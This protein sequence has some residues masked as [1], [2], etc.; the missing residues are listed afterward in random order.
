MSA[1][2][3]ELKE[4]LE[5]TEQWIQYMQQRVAVLHSRRAEW[6]RKLEKLRQDK[7]QVQKSLVERELSDWNK[8][9]LS[10]MKHGAT[11]G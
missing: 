8:A 5:T 4:A 6:D 2:H 1:T 9:C 10:E 7:Q 3:R 11:H